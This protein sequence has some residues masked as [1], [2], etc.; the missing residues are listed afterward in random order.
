[1]TSAIMPIPRADVSVRDATLADVTFIDA[2]QKRHGEQ[3]GFMRTSWIEAKIGAGQVIVAEDSSGTPVGYCMGVDRYFKRD[4]VGIIHQMNVVPGKQRG[5]VGATL[6][7]AM[8]DRAAYGCKLF[9]CWCAQDIEANKF[10]ESM[11]FVALAYRAGSE[12]KARVHIFWQ[13]RIRAGDNETPWWF[14]SQTTGGAM[15]EPRLVFPIPPGTH[16]SEAKPVILPGVMPADESPA[17]S[18]VERKQLTGP[19]AP[20]VPAPRPKA[21][22][23]AVAR[24]D[25]LFFTPPPAPKPACTERSRGETKPR[26]KKPKRKNDPKLVAAARELKDRWLEHVNSGEMLIESVGKYDLTRVL[27]ELPSKMTASMP[28]LPAA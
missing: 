7:K 11:G 8:F 20:K 17:V 23:K 5:F 25:M 15:N 28:L 3:V 1:M 13:K 6:L 21:K 18:G 19:R 22:P 16:W 14:P 26:E 12:K 4:D 27:P 24:A 9:S 2:L 10:W